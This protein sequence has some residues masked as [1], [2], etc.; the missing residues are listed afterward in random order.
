MKVLITGSTGFLGSNLMAEFAKDKEHTP[1]AMLRQENGPHVINDPAFAKCIKHSRPDVV[2]HCAALTDVERCQKHPYEAWEANIR[3]TKNIV[4]ALE[5]GMRLIYISTDM[6]YSG[7]G[8]HREADANENYPPLN[9]YGISKFHGEEI[10]ASHPNH[11]ILRVNFFGYQKGLARWI[12]DSLERMEDINLYYD[13]LFSPL[14][15]KTLSRMI[16]R[17][18]EAAN[19]GIYNLGS[20]QGASKLWFGEEVAK[21]LD[22]PKRPY[23]AKYSGIPRPNDTRMN[24]DKAGIAVDRI[25][26]LA[27]EIQV[28]KEEYNAAHASRTARAV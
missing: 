27:D 23:A 2:I 17:L 22:L 28:L 3:G 15:V 20:Y 8:P 14:H 4:E 16:R 19:T 25:P 13:V 1:Y 26:S 9:T 11:L 10:A 12:I 7:M 6:V 5:P 21:T 24:I 18:A